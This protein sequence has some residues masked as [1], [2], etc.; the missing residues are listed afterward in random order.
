MQGPED[1]RR[2][3]EVH[4]LGRHSSDAENVQD[5]R[6]RGHQ[7]N[8]RRCPHLGRESSW[9]ILLISLFAYM[10]V[11]VCGWFES[12]MQMNFAFYGILI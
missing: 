8:R 10:L 6:R 11:F 5:P 7:R 4:V 2:S 9:L 1:L 12:V 3:D